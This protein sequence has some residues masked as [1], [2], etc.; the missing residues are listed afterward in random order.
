MATL[1]T[2]ILGVAIFVM[3]SFSYNFGANPPIDY[4]RLL[5]SDTQQFAPDGT[6][7][8]YVFADQEIQAATAIANLP[9]QSAQYFSYP[10]GQNIP[11]QPITYLRVAALLLDC[12]AANKARLSSIQKL[13]DVELDPVKA[14]TVLHEQAQAYRDVDDNSGAFMIIEQVN[15]L[16]SF[17][18]RFWRQVQRQSGGG[19]AI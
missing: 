14:A 16:F 19:G 8:I 13:L 17:Q 11:P 18:D 10:A 4:P 7:P 5:I 6:T 1:R 9:F 3:G 2:V 12:L 15:D